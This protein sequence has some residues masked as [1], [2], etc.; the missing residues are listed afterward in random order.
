MDHK[1]ARLPV[2]VLSGFLGAGKTTLL[3]QVLNNRDHLRVAVIVNDMSEINVD[4]R[5]VK[6]GSANLSRVEEQ[7]VELSNGCICCTLREDLLIE[8]SK[9]AEAGKFDYLLIESTGISEPLPVAETFTFADESGQS[10]SQLARLD[11]LVTI[12]DAVN[13]SADFD[14]V[15]ELRDRKIGLDENDARDVVKLLVDQIEFANVLVVSKCDLVD[16]DRIKYLKSLLRSLNPTARIILASQGNIPVREI[17]NTRLFSEHWAESHQDWLSIPRGQESSETE[18]YGFSS[19]VYTARRPFHPQRL[20]EFI[21]R[22]GFG[23]IV[24]SKGLIWLATRNDLGGDWSQAGNVFALNP[25]GEWAAATPPLEWP[26]DEMFQQEIEEVWEEPWGDRRQELVIIGQDLQRDQITQTLNG[27][28]LT[29]EELAAG[30]A[31]WD[32]FEDPFDS[33]DDEA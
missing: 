14:S 15:D 16:E 7:L 31:V 9:L 2:T 4:A 20:F 22:Q 32:V 11:T 28:L 21:Q 29:D 30:P 27:C 3:N 18:E 10:L 26:V 13:F 6:N 19:F 25:A 24:R 23:S 5:L 8:V 17:L 1:P 33:W 12:V